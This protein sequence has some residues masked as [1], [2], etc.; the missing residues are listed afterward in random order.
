MRSL[1]LG[2]L[3][4]ALSQYGFAQTKQMTLFSI[5]ELE[6]QPTIWTVDKQQNFIYLANS[7]LYKCDSSG[8]KRFTQS[9]K[10]LGEIKQILPVNAMKIIVFSEEQQR[11]C[12]LDNTLS[13]NGKCKDLTKYGISQATFVAVSDRSN[14]IWVLDQLNMTV[15]LIDIVQDK[16]QQKVRNFNGIN[17][18]KS[19]IV[20]LAEHNNQLFLWDE[21]GTIFECDNL[22]NLKKTS[23]EHLLPIQFSGQFFVEQDKDKLRFYRSADHEQRII[24]SPEKNAVGFQIEGNDFYFLLDKKIAHYRFK[25]FNY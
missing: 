22:L 9:I 10:E 25:S 12:V 18:S 16:V 14:M 24:A 19:S 8:K 11:I 3:L 2:I 7:T 23:N 1:L 20:G 5:A 13:I 21:K 4:V 15:Y 17:R 6:E